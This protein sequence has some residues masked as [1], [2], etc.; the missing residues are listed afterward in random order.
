MK[1]ET[2]YSKNDLIEALKRVLNTDL[3]QKIPEISPRTPA[4]VLIPF[5]FTEGE[6]Q[7][8]F[9]RRTN[10]VAKHQGEISF[11]G[12]AAESFDRDLIQTAIRESCEEIGVCEDK[13]HVI[14]VLDPV[15]TI[16][17]FCILPVVGI[18]DWPI[19]LTRNQD[20]VEKIFL[21]PLDW[22]KQSGNWYTQEFHYLPGKSRTVLHY[23]DFDGEHVWGITAGL[24]QKIA[25]II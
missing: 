22:L 1:M 4:A 20:E 23:Q 10:G 6:W 12:G 14:G 5:V 24:A 25:S 18:I 19:E 2:N 13:I 21:I 15:A 8:L 17:E 11:P 3:N 16:S 7:L 9:T